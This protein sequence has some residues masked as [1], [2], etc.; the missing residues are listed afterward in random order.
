MR[1]LN[2]S[3]LVAWLGCTLQLSPMAADV[4]MRPADNRNR[5]GKETKVDEADAQKKEEDDA[6]PVPLSPIAEIKANV[7]FLERAVATL[8]PRFTH[9]VL[10]TLTA[11]RKRLDDQALREAI[12]DICPRGIRATLSRLF[13]FWC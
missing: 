2:A 4:E 1:V 3:A 9:R 12:S 6:K 13:S 5:S 10:R 7:S 8:E 11:L